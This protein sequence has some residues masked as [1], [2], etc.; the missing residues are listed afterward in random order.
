MP[1]DSY[2]EKLVKG[3][4]DGL[5]ALWRLLGLDPSV[6]VATLSAVELAR[7][8]RLLGLSPREMIAHLRLPC[9]AR[10][11]SRPSSPS[12]A[13]GDLASSGRA[14]PMRGRPGGGR[15]GRGR[16]H[17]A[18]LPA[19]CGDELLTAYARIQEQDAL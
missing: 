16:S 1:L 17:R 10:A 15:D 8:G 14:G 2:L 19:P 5:A 7:V 3:A 18:P 9:S 13:R 6:H 12:V 4:G 11:P